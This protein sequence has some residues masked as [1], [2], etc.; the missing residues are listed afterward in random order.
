MDAMPPIDYDQLA[1][2]EF[3]DVKLT[4]LEAKV[5]L[6]MAALDVK[7]A[8]QM[9]LTFLLHLASFGGLVAYISSVT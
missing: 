1:T 8:N 3:V 6:S 2:K 5:S 9:R 7:L 4:A